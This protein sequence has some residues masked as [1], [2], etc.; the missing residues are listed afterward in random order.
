MLLSVYERTYEYMTVRTDTA[1]VDDPR[2]SR[3][4]VHVLA[5][6]HHHAEA[7]L[8]GQSEDLKT[9]VTATRKARV[10]LKLWCDVTTVLF[11]LFAVV[12]VLCAFVNRCKNNMEYVLTL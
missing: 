1:L 12:G 7:V 3:V 9:V 10:T 6:L 11:A 2:V 5:V 8:T 4:F